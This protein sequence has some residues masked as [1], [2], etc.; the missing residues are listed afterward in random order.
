MNRSGREGGAQ[1]LDF[2]SVDP[3]VFVCGAEETKRGHNLINVFVLN[4]VSVMAHGITKARW[5]DPASFVE[6]YVT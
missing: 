1:N 6:S 3:D 4:Y 5:S 2:I